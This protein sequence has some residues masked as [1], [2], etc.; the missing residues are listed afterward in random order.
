MEM[1]GIEPES[2]RFD[3]RI[4]TSVVGRFMSPDGPL[5]T[6]VH[7]RPDAETREPLFRTLSVIGV[8]HS[9]FV[10]P[11]PATGQRAGQA[12]VAL[13]RRPAVLYSLMQRGGEQ[14]S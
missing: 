5:P 8:R 4:S 10:T 14:R 7:V 3:P 2:E 1:S 6:E 12:D 11:G 9:G 13:L